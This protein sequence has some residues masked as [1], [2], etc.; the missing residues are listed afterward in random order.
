MKECVIRVYHDVILQCCEVKWVFY[1]N[2]TFMHTAE[3]AGS[4]T[5]KQLL[6][7]GKGIYL[8]FHICWLINILLFFNGIACYT[9]ECPPTHGI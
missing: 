6:C 8:K 2:Y 5:S 7:N 9:C 4:H 1:Q 3:L